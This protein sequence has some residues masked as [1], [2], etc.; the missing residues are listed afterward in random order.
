MPT[1]RPAV[2]CA[3]RTRSGGECGRSAGWGTDHRGIGRCRLHGG[4]TPSHVRGAKLERIEVEMARI[5]ERYGVGRDVN[6][7]DALLEL[8]HA[9]AGIVDFWDSKVRA[10]DDLS[11]RGLGGSTDVHHYVRAAERARRDYARTAADCARLGIEARRDALSKRQG[12]MIVEV[13]AGTVRRLGADPTDPTVR[14]EVRSAL[15]DVLDAAEAAA[16]T[17]EP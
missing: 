10:L 14:A 1:G 2:T 11:E 12:E 5:A 8:L 16:Q 4:C 7:L 6:V 9:Q 13:I 17:A 15:A 3:A